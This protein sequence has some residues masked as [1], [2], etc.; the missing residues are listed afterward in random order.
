[1]LN[2]FKTSLRILVKQKG[3]TLLNLLGLITG[4]VAF[5]FIYLYIQNEISYDR[6]WKN[7]RHLF[8]L[9]AEYSTGDSLNKLALTSYP[10]A[11]ILKKTFP[12][13]LQS[14][15]LFFNDP[16]DNNAV[17]AVRYEGK[18]YD[19]P[20][21][22]FADA[23]FFKVFDYTFTEGNP[24]SC[25]VKPNSLVIS[26]AIKKQIFGSA[27]ALGKKLQTS[28]RTYTVTGVFKK[29]STP[30]HLRFN[31]L[32]SFS[33]L[34]KTELATLDSS[35]LFSTCYTYVR[36]AKNVNVKSFDTHVNKMMDTLV[37]DYIKKEKIEIGGGYYHVHFQPI[38][39]IHFSK[40][41]YFDSHTNNQIYYLYL[42]GII[43]FFILLTASINYINLTTARAIKKA[44]ETG[45]RKVIGAN[46]KQ[47]LMQYISESL[48]LIFIAFFV[49][50]S[51]IELLLPKLNELVQQHIV[52]IN[53]LTSGSGVIF[54]LILI[55]IVFLLSLLSGSFPALVLYSLDPAAVLRGNNI[56]LANGKRRQLTTAKLRKVLVVFQYLVAIG[57]IIAT[58]IISNQVH[59]VKNINLGFNQNQLL[60]VNSPP[61]TSFARREASFVATLKQGPSIK[62]VTSAAN[63]PG[64]LTGRIL[65]RVGNNSKSEVYTMNSYIVGK[66]YFKMLEIPIVKGRTFS[67]TMH[68]DSTENLI[69]NEA[70]VKYLRLN[71]SNAIGATIQTPTGEKGKIIGIVKNFNFS[72]LHQAIEPL[73]FMYRPQFPRYILIRYKENEKAQTLDYVMK[74]WDKFNPGYN[75]YYTSL[76][77]KID[78]LYGPDQRM[79]SLFIYFSLIVLFISLLGLY[80]LSAYLIEQRSKEISIRKVLGGSNNQI[81]I[82]LLK[83]YLALVVLAGALASP[84]VYFLIKNWLESFAYHINLSIFYS[85]LS[86]LFVCLISALTVL[87]QSNRILGKSPSEY[88]KYE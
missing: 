52:L 38:Y 15:R 77:Q 4:L 58:V 32:I 68:D 22:T 46:R 29:P 59:Y 35:L 41:L 83:E 21:M 12:E 67:Q 11:K 8:R 1:M 56:V 27:P 42:F 45:V 25:L 19:I 43:A 57:M 16:S 64:Y 51:V 48:L 84:I 53:S 71:D 49:A 33:S 24:D 18:Y 88:L 79:L 20:Y 26:E 66:D 40:G 28:V 73:V 14:T 63:L 7:Y 86:I 55:L 5:V 6:G 30:S 78:D 82:L 76:K 65:F 13:V 74:T 34:D 31:A 10:Q 54:G 36:L 23:Q 17:S 75:I 60:V 70:A 44:R 81:L 47:M 50:L 61:D 37:G 3:Y 39:K 9:T 80:G 69:I 72:S 62:M 85:I 87:I 2:F